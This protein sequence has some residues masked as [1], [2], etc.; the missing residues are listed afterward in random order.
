MESFIRFRISKEKLN[1]LDVNIQVMEEDLSSATVVLPIDTNNK[2]SLHQIKEIVDGKAY[3][4]WDVFFKYTEKEIAEARLFRVKINKTVETCGEECGTVYD[5]RPSCPI[6]GAG[7]V[8]KGPLILS[9]VPSFGKVDICKTI[10][11]EIIVSKRFQE[12]VVKHNLLGMTFLPILVKGRHSSH[13]MQLAAINSVIISHETRFGIDYFD[14]INIPYSD[15]RK[16]DICGHEITM[17]RE[18]YVCPNQDLMG[19]NLLSELYISEES[20]QSHSFDLARTAQYVGVKRGMLRPEPLY[21]C[22]KEFF[23]MVKHEN[24]LGM[25]FEIAKIVTTKK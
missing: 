21:V 14:S 9:K 7:R 6:C 13:A 23:E 17:P 15:E 10:G 11:G 25:N 24:V 20:L 18:I 1:R 8:Q 2:V 3:Y 16:I 19:L 12:L 4:D 5:D 22:T